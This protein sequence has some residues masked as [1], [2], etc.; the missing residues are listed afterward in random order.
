MM[1]KSITAL[2]KVLGILLG[3]CCVFF[4]GCVLF[5]Y[6]YTPFP[7]QADHILLI[8]HVNIIDVENDSVLL[9]HH[10][11][12][13]NGIIDAISDQPI[14]LTDD[15]IRVIN[16]G[17][18]YLIS[19]LWDMHAHLTKQSPYVAYPEF[20]LHGVTH[21]RDMRGAYSDRDPFAGVTEKLAAWNKQVK[22]GHLIGPELHG[23]TSFALDGPSPMFDNSPDYFNCSTPEEAIKL[24]NHFKENNIT[25]IKVYNN[26]P[27]EAF[28][29]LMEEATKAGIEVAGHKPVSVSTI[30]AS[31]AGMKSMEHARFFIWDS[32]KDSENLR[33]SPDARAGD[34][35]Q[36]RKRMLESHDSVMLEKMFQT[37][38]RNNTWYCP[39][40]LTRKADAFADDSSFRERYS[41]INPILK[42]LSF[43][44]LDAVI[45]ED[46]TPEGRKVYREFYLKTLEISG[47][48]AESG[49]KVLAG[50]DVPELPGSSLHD[51]LLELSS[52]GLPPYEVLRST[53][54]YPA[55]Y[56]GI[57]DRYGSVK[58]GK[59]ADLVLLFANPVEDMKNSRE[60]YGII[61][62]GVFLNSDFLEDLEN[63][64]KSRRTGIIMTCKL[65][66]DVL[67]YMTL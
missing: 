31:D 44:D 40:H 4:I 61:S 34:N 48:A 63:K 51:E 24:V 59:V 57:S 30:D 21:V 20:V 13:V 32:F 11:L 3:F 50:S 46:P 55:M 22:A 47:K 7:Q 18:M 56:Y 62:N 17:N 8:K 23:Y 29:T 33:K 5:P 65:I 10:V 45:Q 38:V 66:W 67:I 6:G 42:L 25:L 36:L 16:A 64:V 43:E 54:M 1:I 58:E 26:I 28:F 27:P 12:I 53:T 15:S 60:I 39:T 37:F 19:G 35:T 41:H 14:S 49:V 52:A 9:N 2:F